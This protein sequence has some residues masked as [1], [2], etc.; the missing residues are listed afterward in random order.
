MKRLCITNHV[1]VKLSKGGESATT[2]DW[3]ERE[4]Y[5][6]REGFTQK[7]PRNKNAKR[8]FTTLDDV[9]ERNCNL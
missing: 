6:S 9:S 7:E 3:N 8:G 2:D 4:I 5:R 1:E